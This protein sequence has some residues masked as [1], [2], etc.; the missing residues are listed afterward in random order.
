MT[1]ST[2]T[3]KISTQWDWMEDADCRSE[4][5]T[6]FFSREGE[7]AYEKND[8][9]E[10]ARQICRR[11]PVLVDCRRYALTRREKYGFWGGMSE[12]ERA[13][14]QPQRRRARRADAA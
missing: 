2:A 9:E 7:R 4:D 10:R 5:T 1:N 3:P 6:L 8:R 11:C 14:A 12:D 13:D